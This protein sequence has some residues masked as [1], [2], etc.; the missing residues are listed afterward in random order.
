LIK[1]NLVELKDTIRPGTTQGLDFVILD[2]MRELLYRAAG[3]G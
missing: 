2:E 1:K 3:R